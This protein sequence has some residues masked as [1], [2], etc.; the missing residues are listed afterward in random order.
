MHL[1]TPETTIL[2]V[3]PR[4][5]T[6][7]WFWFF[8]HVGTSLSLNVVWPA[9]RLSS[10]PA[11]TWKSLIR[12]FLVTFCR[13]GAKYSAQFWLVENLK[14][15]LCT[16]DWNVSS[17]CANVTWP[18]KVSEY[19]LIQT[20]NN[21]YQIKLVK[22]YNI[23]YWYKKRF[24]IHIFNRVRVTHQNLLLRNFIVR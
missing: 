8:D 24:G 15:T 2:L 18:S 21:K 10:W 9:L 13:L 6:F 7:E 20:N 3:S 11:P 4:I 1:A 17:T 19:A 14:C 23:I 12:K 22:L 5:T 16:C